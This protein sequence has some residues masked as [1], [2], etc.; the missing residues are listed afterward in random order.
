MRLGIVPAAGNATRWDGYPKELLPIS[1]SET[2]MSRAVDSLK[3][4]GC[5]TVL[6]I[7]NPS[8][9][10][11]HAYHLRD[12]EQ[13]LL[14]MQQG[15]ELWAAFE[16]ALETPADEY[17]FLMPDTY[18]PSRPFPPSL[19]KEFGMGLFETEEPERFGVLR[20]DRIIDKQSGESP[21]QAWGVLAWTGSVAQY[22]KSRS[23][24][25]HTEAINDALQVFGYD[26]W[27]LDYY[28]DMGSMKLYIEFLLR[29]YSE[30]GEVA[31]GIPFKASAED[32]SEAE[33]TPIG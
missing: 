6:V 10:H 4:C 15:K 14:A 27:H 5:E 23:Y 29:R 24:S 3:M 30:D 17:F 13:V 1:S 18:V 8:K 32:V 12:H 33:I 31:P 7:S 21:C 2:F 16:T 22:W 19:D 9:I 20:G 25:S 28:C 26:S 11:L